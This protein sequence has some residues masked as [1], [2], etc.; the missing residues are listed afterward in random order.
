MYVKPVHILLFL[1]LPFTKETARAQPDSGNSIAPRRVLAGDT[2]VRLNR[3]GVNSIRFDGIR[4]RTPLET[5]TKPD[6]LMRF[7]ET[8]P[9]VEK[10]DTVRLTLKPYNIFNTGY[11]YA[12][13]DSL[14]IRNYLDP[15][16]EGGSSSVS[17]GIG[18]VFIFD[19][20]RTLRRIFWKSERA[21]RR[22]AKRAYVIRD[23]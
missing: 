20:E 21:R 4:R 23:Y 22:N 16:W 14:Q 7:D 19:A 1:L 2:V 11:K 17:F 18:F 10:E 13:E 6:F 15:G 12:S 5:T 9:K 3:E 8:L